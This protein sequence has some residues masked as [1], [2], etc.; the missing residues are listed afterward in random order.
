MIDIFQNDSIEYSHYDDLDIHSL[1]GVNPEMDVYD[2]EAFKIDIRENGIKE[3]L[4]MYRNKIIDGRHRIKAARKLGITQVPYK[5]LKQNYTK[6]ELLNILRSKHMRRNLDPLAKTLMAY[7]YFEEQ[8]GSITR[9]DAEN[10]YGI[11]GRSISMVIKIKEILGER[12]INELFAGEYVEYINDKGIKKL[13]RS[14][15][16]IY[17]IALEK[18]KEKITVKPSNIHNDRQR[19]AWLKEAEDTVDKLLDHHSKE[20]LELIKEMI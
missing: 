3:P 18:E 9:A 13:T 6:R 19:D 1:A 16:G 17:A 10:K 20:V 5:I 15:Q 11:K 14:I 12:V 2:F 4:W 7:R 8:G